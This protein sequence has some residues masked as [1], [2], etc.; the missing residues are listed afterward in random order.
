M[1][2]SANR[3]VR[4]RIPELDAKRAWHAQLAIA[5]DDPVIISLEQSCRTKIGC[6]IS[7]RTRSEG[8]K[9][10]WTASAVGPDRPG[11]THRL[12]PPLPSA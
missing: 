11:Q 1:L 9:S 4:C 12:Y 6:G 8:A 10:T 7:L 3:A 2:Q 5:A